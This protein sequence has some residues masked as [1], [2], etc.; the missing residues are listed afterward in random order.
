MSG[1]RT[2]DRSHN[3]SHALDWLPETPRVHSHA[4]GY[5]D[6]HIVVT[7]T[8]ASVRCRHGKLVV[9]G[10]SRSTPSNART[11]R[12]APFTDRKTKGMITTIP[13]AGHGHASTLDA[14]PGRSREGSCGSASCWRAHPGC[15]ARAIGR[16]SHRHPCDEHG[17]GR[18]WGMGSI[19]LR[20]REARDPHER[21]RRAVASLDG[22]TEAHLE[23]LP[24]RWERLQDLIFTPGTCLRGRPLE[25]HRPALA[26]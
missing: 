21:L 4:L 8:R 13:V 6:V 17:G 2:N 3:T 16:W 20:T 9:H 15:T 11:R 14:G 10:A 18:S 26:P 1:R 22:I 12:G 25:R 7:A 19:A 23:S 24:K 5:R